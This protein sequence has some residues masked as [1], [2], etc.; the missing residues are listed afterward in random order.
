MANSS[1]S[2]YR[3]P[4][5]SPVAGS[6]GLPPE[7]STTSAA[8]VMPLSSTT[9]AE[10]TPP[11]SAAA[12]APVPAPT[13]PW[14]TRPPSSRRGGARAPN[15]A[16]G[17]LEKS[18]P[19][20]RSNTTAAG[21]IGTTWCG[22]APIWKP[23]RASLEPGHHAAG[24]VEPVGAAAG[25]ADRVDVAD[26]VR[27]GRSRSVSRVPGPAAADV[28]A[29]DRAGRRQHDRR[30]GQPTPPAARVVADGDPADVG[31]V[32]AR[33]GPHDVVATAQEAV[34][35]LDVHVG[36]GDEVVDLDELV[37]LVGDPLAARAVDDRRH[38]GP[39]RDDR[40]VGRAGHAAEARASRR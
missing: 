9:L 6:T 33:P 39:R 19:A 28:D 30:A 25:E 3:A 35:R 11:F 5:S 14:R 18:P 27:P 10:P 38:A 29:A 1:P 8:T 37:G 24:G 23:R 22:S 36:V 15:S 26:H 21:T 20:P 40:A 17:R 34:G 16:S 4:H 2:P 7:L 32:V 31:E 13:V 12:W